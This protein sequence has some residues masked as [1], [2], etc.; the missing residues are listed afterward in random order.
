LP[1]LRSLCLL[2][3]TLAPLAAS[4]P[5]SGTAREKLLATYRKG[6]A[7]WEEG[8]LSAAIPHVEEAV[9]LAPRAFGPDHLQTADLLNRLGKL[10]YHT[11]QFAL[12][13]A[14]FRHSLRIREAQL[15]PDHLLVAESL[16]N[17]AIQFKEQGRYAE[18]DAPLRRA[19]AIQERAT[20]DDTPV[21]DSLDNLAFLYQRLGR[22][23]EATKLFTRALAIRRAKLGEE[24]PDTAQSLRN[25]AD[26]LQYEGKGDQAR[27]YYERSLRIWEAKLGPTHRKVAI[28]LHDLGDLHLHQGRPNDAIPL[29]ERCVK[30]QRANEGKEDPEVSLGLILDNLALAHGCRGDWPKAAATMDEAQRIYLRFVNYSLPAQPEAEQL[31]FLRARFQ[32]TLHRGLSL[33][34]AAQADPALCAQS[35]AWLLNGKGVAHQTLAERALL[36]RDRKDPATAKLVDRLR[37]VRDERSRLTYQARARGQEAVTTRRLGELARQEQDLIKEIGERRGR[38]RKGDG[39][40]A[41]DGV[42]RALPEDAVLIEIA[43]FTRTTFKAGESPAEECYA[44]WVIPAAGK[45][46]VRVVDLGPAEAIDDA[47]WAVRLALQKGPASVARSGEAKAEKDLLGPLEALSRRVV[48]PLLKYA[49]NARRWVVSPDGDLWLVPWAALRLA[50]GR[51]VVEEHEVRYVVSGRDL[52]AGQTGAAATPPLVLADP[53]FD[54]KPTPVKVAQ[55][56]RAARPA[57][58]SGALGETRWER[59]PGT[60]AEAKVI[61]PALQRMAGAKPRVLTGAR[62]TE[63]AFKAA[64]NPRVL[65]LSTHGFFLEDQAGP[66]TERV[67]GSEGRGIARPDRPAARPR[68]KAKSG[69]P[70]ENPLL[71][72]GLV[73]AGANHPQRAAAAGGDDGVLTGLEIASADLRGTELVVLSACETGLGQVHQGEGVSGLRQAFQLAGARAVAA[74]LWKVADRET[75]QLVG[76]FFDHLARKRPPAEALRSAQ[77]AMIRQRRAQ[78]GAAHP[79]YWA[80]FTL[81]GR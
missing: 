27:T 49:G 43:R 7:L 34:L 62:A 57:T 51:Y 33:G 70:V 66:P 50:T 75:A 74:T 32:R 56:P 19:L 35:A 30:I 64:P 12:A 76:A 2:A 59:L 10:Y 39:W 78:H 72:C 63:R 40:V 37:A 20:P 42:R 5:A 53:D 67:P 60:A 38:S 23:A 8:K 16:N 6:H 31:T 80:A 36:D 13:E 29:L 68:P 47:V 54:L 45:G 55:A 14:Q 52:V 18:A 61:G 71:R 81:T 46:E 22:H 48:H 44:A 21:A 1:C 28:A 79:Y 24:H 11:S 9:R 4:G 41:L 17:L 26:Q 25:V 65:V 69:G 15:G 77:L 3:A 73:L 58:R